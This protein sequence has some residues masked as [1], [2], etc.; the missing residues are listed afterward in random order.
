MKLFGTLRV[1][2]CALFGHRYQTG[3]WQA[4]PFIPGKWHRETECS[5]CGHTIV[6]SARC[7][8][9]PLDVVGL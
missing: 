4:S 3:L 2:A 9:K 7:A 1:F 6:T 8:E 5:R